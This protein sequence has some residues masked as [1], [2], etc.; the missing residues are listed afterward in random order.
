MT[1]TARYCV[2]FGLTGCYMPDSN[3]GPTIFHT[4]KALAAFIRHELEHYELPANLFREV[5]IRRLWSFIKAHGSSSAHFHLSHK[6][7]SLS[8]SGLTEEE[9]NSLDTEE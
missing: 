3:D 7:Y 8:F 5:R 1:T 6:G 9:F 2:T 4:R